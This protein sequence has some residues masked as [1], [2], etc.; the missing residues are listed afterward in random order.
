MTATSTTTALF[1][2]PFASSMADS[3]LAL[4]VR[5][6]N[7]ATHTKRLP[8]HTSLGFARLDHAS[9]LFLER[10]FSEGRWTLS[11]RTWDHPAAESVHQWHVLAAEAASQLDPTVRLP[12]RMAAS[13][14]EVQQRQVGRAQNKRLARIRRHLVGVG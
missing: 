4:L 11:A 13:A 5:W 14:P 9:G 8:S 10:G 1:E 3:D 7:L 2:V 6:L 12:E